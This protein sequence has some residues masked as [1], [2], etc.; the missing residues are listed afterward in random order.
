M[1]PIGSFAISQAA[2]PGVFVGLY[3]LWRGS[4]RAGLVIL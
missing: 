3:P 1:A 4:P 2:L